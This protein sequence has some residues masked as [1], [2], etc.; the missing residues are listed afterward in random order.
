ME[1]SERIQVNEFKLGDILSSGWR[2]YKSRFKTI[3]MIILIIYVPINILLSFMTIGTPQAE[4]GLSELRYYFQMQQFLETFIGVLAIMAIAFV[5]E[6]SLAGEDIGYRRALRVSISR[7][8][9]A[10]GTNI[11]AG[12]IIFGLFLL[13]IIPGVIWYV[14]YTFIVFVV[15]LRGTGGK[16]ALDYSKSLVKGKWWKVF[17]ITLLFIILGFI[18]YFIVDIPFW[19]APENILTYTI[20]YTIGDIFNALFTVALVVFFLN[21]DYLKN[22]QQPSG[23][24]DS[25]EGSEK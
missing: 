15:V 24:S 17:G 20:S 9:S 10:I 3:L 2:I 1:L 23:I 21:L 19:F 16:T 13:L 7:W 14:Y 4:Q 11:L 18:I 6:R 8:G 5:V 25:E 22:A 12:L